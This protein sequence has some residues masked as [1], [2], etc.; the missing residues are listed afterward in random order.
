MLI[1]VEGKKGKCIKHNSIILWLD[2]EAIEKN[3][4]KWTYKQ[5][6]VVYE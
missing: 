6:L 2:W 5:F 4:N 1:L 3:T